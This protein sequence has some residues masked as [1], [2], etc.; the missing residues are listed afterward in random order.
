MRGRIASRSASGNAGGRAVTNRW[1]GEAR[2]REAASTL[3]SL[4]QRGGWSTEMGPCLLGAGGVTYRSARFPESWPAAVSCSVSPHQSPREGWARMSPQHTRWTV[5]A[6]WMSLA[7]IVFV[8]ADPSSGRSLLALALLA[9]VP[10]TV[11]I[12]LWKDPSP[13]IAEVLHG[14]ENRR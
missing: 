4:S 6:S 10:P 3:G 8:L 9:L 13:A 7:L 1:D 5:V 2:S 14:V 11:M 12:A